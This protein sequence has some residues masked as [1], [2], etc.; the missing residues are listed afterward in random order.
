MRSIHF[1]GLASSATL[2]L[3]ASLL[4]VQ[5]AI[6]SPNAA[7]GA[8]LSARCST[9]HGSNGFSVAT[10]IPN[11][12]GQRYGYLL[13]QL[14]RF[15]SGQRGNGLMDGIARP[16][17]D[18]Q[19]EDI[20]AYF[21]S[22]RTQMSMPEPLPIAECN[23]CHNKEKGRSMS[24]NTPNLAG[25]HYMYL[26]RQLRDFKT[27]ARVSPIMNAMVKPLSEKQLERLAAYYASMPI[28][29]IGTKHPD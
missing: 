27:G 29:P 28:R 16:L 20:A 4:S 25:Q 10:N 6:A 9:C 22:I 8:A 23:A 18:E 21:S 3:A 1:R 24:A 14:K 15:K 13:D 7:K 12:A 17:S 11:L 19:M 26:L 2:A 5:F